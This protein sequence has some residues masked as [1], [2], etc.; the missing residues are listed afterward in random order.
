MIRKPDGLFPSLFL[1][2]NSFRV[3]SVKK[4]RRFFVAFGIFSVLA[5][6]GFT[7]LSW[8]FVRELQNP[9]YRETFS[10]RVAGLGPGGIFVLLGLQ[11][12]QIVVAIIPGG[13][14]EFI[15]G[16]AYGAWAGLGIC[17]AGC[18]IAS[19]LIFIVVKKFGFSFLRR[20]FGEKKI[21][22][23]K[24]LED[25]KKTAIVVFILFLLPGM[26]KDFLTWLA[27]LSRLSLAQFVILSVVARTPVMFS[28]TVMGDS[29]IQG[30]GGL[31]LV[32]FIVIAL[33][34]LGGIRFRDK[35]IG[36]FSQED[37]KQSEAVPK[38]R[39]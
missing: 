4:N 29:M 7:V 33:A 10:S 38:C 15:A 36:G 12:L 25:S 19:S 8:W 24:F 16:A 3:E 21:K 26:P 30:N 39:F 35:I 9:V 37:K 31:L 5:A 22:T 20:F 14:V 27:P 23:W 11:I 2:Y 1:G 34:G 17:A 13:P 18:V 28:S 32:V 6:I